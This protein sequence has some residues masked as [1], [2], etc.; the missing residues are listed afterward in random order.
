[1]SLMKVDSGYRFFRALRPRA[2]GSGGASTPAGQRAV[3][4]LP[5][6]GH[7]ARRAVAVEHPQRRVADVGQLVKHPRR[8]VGGLAGRETSALFAQAHLARAFDDE[9]DFFLLLVVP[10][11]LAAVRAR[12]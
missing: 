3:Q 10:R 4:F 5:P 8:D 11:H 2:V 6:V 1:M 12:A 9:V 7:V